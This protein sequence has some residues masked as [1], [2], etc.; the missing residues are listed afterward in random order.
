MIPAVIGAIAAKHRA[1]GGGGSTHLYWRLVF[2]TST[3]PGAAGGLDLNRAVFR[4][5]PGG[6]QAAVGGVA[7][8][9]NDGGAGGGAGLYPPAFL[10]DGNDSTYWDTYTPSFN[11][12]IAVYQ[13]PAPVEIVEYQLMTQYAAYMARAWTFDWSDNGTTWTTKD[14]RSGISWADSVA[15]TF[16]VP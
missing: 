7:T 11:P 4:T 13:F 6:P 12:S 16:T 2:N 10:F 9:S 1:S 15:Q 14:T 8:G 3:T 5:T